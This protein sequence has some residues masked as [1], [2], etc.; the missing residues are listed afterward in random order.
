MTNSTQQFIETIELLTPC[1]DKLYPQA[2]IL[3]ASLELKKIYGT[4]TWTIGG[5]V[6]STN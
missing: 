5:K 6:L 2:G 1:Q 4:E 3:H